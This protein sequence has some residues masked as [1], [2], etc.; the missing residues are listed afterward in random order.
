MAVDHS[1]QKPLN[2]KNNSSDLNISELERFK[3]I[4]DNIELHSEMQISHH[5]RNSF[6]LVS[7]TDN[8]NVREIE[9]ESISD[10]QDSKKILW[11]ASKLINEI[12]KE[13]WMITL[14]RKKGLKSLKEFERELCKKEI[15]EIGEDSFIKKILEIIPSSEVI[16]VN[17]LENINIQK[18]EKNE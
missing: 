11:K 6:K 10:N 1:E 7:L 14:S 2:S 5:L 17:E 8:K 12:T 15:R 13:R 3:S 9:L 18:K 4:V 16:S